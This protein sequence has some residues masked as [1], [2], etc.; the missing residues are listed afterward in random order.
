MP[1]RYCC[2]RIAHH[3]SSSCDGAHDTRSG[4][5]SLRGMLRNPADLC[6][7]ALPKGC[8]CS[9][10]GPAQNSS[11]ASWKVASCSLESAWA[12]DRSTT[13]ASVKVDHN[14]ICCK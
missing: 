2:K 4:T 7:R 13:A 10:L 8:K 12:G 9:K 11:D 3:L 5:Q 6:Q 14:G 1:D